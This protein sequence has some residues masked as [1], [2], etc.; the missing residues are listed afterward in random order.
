[1][2]N[3]VSRY[4]NNKDRLIRSRPWRPIR[5]RRVMPGRGMSSQASSHD[6]NRSSGNKTS[7]DEEAKSLMMLTRMQ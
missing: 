7:E 4:G 2:V 6:P 1:M 3:F 5:V